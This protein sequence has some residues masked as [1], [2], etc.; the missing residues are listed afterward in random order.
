MAFSVS[1]RYTIL[2]QYSAPLAKI[3]E[4]TKKA[5]AQINSF[6]RSVNATSKSL[7]GLKDKTSQTGLA[8]L[9]RKARLANQQFD[10]LGN[11]VNQYSSS[12]DKIVKN[13][14]QI[15]QSNKQVINSNRKTSESF[16]SS[17]DKL[18]GFGMRATTAR[19]AIAGL[20]GSLGLGMA[21][22]KSVEFQESMNKL[23]AVTLASEKQLNSMR[24]A[25]M[26]L[27]STTQFTAGQA[28]DG[29]TFLAMAGLDTNQVL[30]AIPG[31]LQ[32]A[33]A[34]GI[35]L[36]TAADIA[37]NVL[38]Q[39]GLGVQDLTRVNDVLAKVQSK[40]N[41]DI[42]QAAEAMKNVGT[43][44]NGVGMSIEQ[45][46]AMI[47]ALANAGVK[48]G[49]AG[50]LLRNALLRTVNPSKKA[51]GSLQKLGIDLRNFVTPDGKIKDFTKLLDVLQKK[52]ASTAELFTIFEERGG[53]AIQALL[54]QGKPAIDQ[55]TKSLENSG[56][57]AERMAKIQMKGLPGAIKSLKS[58]V[59]GLI[60]TITGSNI[61][62][63]LEKIINKITGFVRSMTQ[64]NPQLLTLIGV[65]ASFVAILAPALFLVGMMA[66]GLSALMSP[67]T[68]IVV[69]IAG[70]IAAIS[71][72]ALSNSGMIMSLKILLDAFSPI[73]EVVS[74]VTG[75]F[76]EFFDN[77][78]G[79][80]S[81]I[82]MM[83]IG[84]EGLA[85]VIRVVLS[86][87]Q[88]LINATRAIKS[89]G[90][91]KGAFKAGFGAIKSAIMPKIG[92]VRQKKLV[93][94]E[95]LEFQRRAEQSEMQNNQG[96]GIVSGAKQVLE[97]RL[98]G[99][100]K[101]SAGEGSRVDKAEIN[102]NMP[103]NLGINMG[104]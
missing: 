35:D 33:A 68:L 20:A 5:Q 38:A 22:N 80:L 90:G 73:G 88:A 37:T 4:T 24:K 79:G 53:R 18:Y 6:K 76:G 101:V 21:V 83:R 1:Y 13:N 95:G 47:G 8:D 10:N 30:Q 65:V 49:E 19:S 15:V 16:K 74:I 3:A 14:K 27:G 25:A 94:Q 28:A 86:P 63:F 72:L 54:T 102:S 51:L 64:L 9:A 45:T 57:T 40:A 23:N 100:I 29:M 43:A 59:E 71:A 26:E 99:M 7:S 103:G 70:L 77:M 39:M 82:D 56:G 66:V 2:D 62:E 58:A 81:F 55:L 12:L 85:K 44:A 87:L 32:L 97:A 91:I 31:T 75:V 42:L 84:I 67:I 96:T 11:E 78:S 61:G 46:T 93:A 34:G 36:A 89:G 69:G 104:N 92:D 41:T 48:G 17:K 52:N 98:G 50:T 60:L